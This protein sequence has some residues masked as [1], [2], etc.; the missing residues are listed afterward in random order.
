MIYHI[1]TN[2]EWQSSQDKQHY[3]AESLDTQGFIHLSEK[4]QIVGVADAIFTGRD[5]L[6]ILVVNP[7]KL[8]AELRYEAPDP[9]IPKEHHEGELFPHLYGVLNFDAVENV[10]EFPCQENGK[11]SLPELLG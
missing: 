5:D 3:E 2:G 8:K 1:T 11:F 10:V 9:N 6:I 7:A 4:H